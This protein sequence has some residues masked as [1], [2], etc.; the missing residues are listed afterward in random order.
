MT[1]HYPDL[2][3]ASDWLK[4][5]SLA[6][7]LIRSII[8]DNTSSVWNFSKLSSD[9]ILVVASRNIGFFFLRLGDYEI[10]NT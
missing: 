7:R 5:V 3:S 1:C 10:I 9:V 8:G 2:G 6:A 4:Q